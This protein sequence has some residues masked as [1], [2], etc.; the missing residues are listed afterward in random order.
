[1]TQVRHKVARLKNAGRG[2]GV[3]GFLQFSLAIGLRQPLIETTVPVVQPRMV[4]RNQVSQ[5]AGSQFPICSMRFF[6]RF[7]RPKRACRRVCFFTSRHFALNMRIRVVRLPQVAL[8]S[9]PVFA[10]VMPQPR[11]IGPSLVICGGIKLP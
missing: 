9:E 11:H 6:K 7:Y 3:F 8:K 5:H 10:E 4:T 2:L 1:M